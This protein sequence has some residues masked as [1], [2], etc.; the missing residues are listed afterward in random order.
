M[1][2]FK[3]RFDAG[4]REKQATGAG[5]AVR[6]HFQIKLLSTEWFDDPQ[7]SEARRSCRRSAVENRAYARSGAGRD[8]K[9]IWYDLL[10]QVRE[11]LWEGK[12]FSHEHIDGKMIAINAMVSFELAIRKG[13]ANLAAEASEDHTIRNEDLTFH[14][15]DPVTINN[16][17]VQAIRGGT[18]WFRSYV[19]VDN[20]EECC[21]KGI[22]HKTGL[23]RAGKRIQRRTAEEEELLEDLV[24]W[25]M[26]SGSG[27]EDPLF[28]RYTQF[29]G[30]PRMLK[31]CTGKMVAKVIKEF[32]ERA[33]LNPKEYAFHSLRKGCITQLNAFGVGLEEANARGNYARASVMVQ[34][35]YNQNDTGRGPSAASGSGVGRRM[36]VE[37]AQKQRGAAYEA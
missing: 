11:E 32:V 34:T 18:I 35:V 17:A 2:F 10:A 16:E 12:D 21:V 15:F 27:P 20:V 22:T 33:G 7:L 28:S 6:K 23:I 13:E 30:K 19:K 1:Y 3:K 37:D 5:A 36:G 26:Y 24:E 9:P 14:L 31:A 4:L 8:K 25:V 29:P